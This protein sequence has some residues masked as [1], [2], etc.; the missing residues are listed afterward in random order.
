[1]RG[2][3]PEGKLTSN[4]GLI[5][6]KT[7]APQRSRH[8]G[9]DSRL[10]EGLSTEVTVPFPSREAAPRNT[11]PAAQGPGCQDTQGQAEAG[12]AQ[13]SKDSPATGLPQAVQISAPTSREHPDQCRL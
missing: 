11:V 8:L 6:V 9:E 12:R 13:D 2:G 7:E 5:S 10:G 3:A 4:Q 1:M